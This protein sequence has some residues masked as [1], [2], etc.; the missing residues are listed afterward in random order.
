MESQNGSRSQGKAMVVVVVAI[1]FHFPR[2]LGQ[3][4]LHFVFLP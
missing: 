3:S 4:E 1:F 2:L